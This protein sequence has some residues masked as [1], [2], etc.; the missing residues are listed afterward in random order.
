MNQWEKAK[1]KTYGNDFRGE[2]VTVFK[3]PEYCGLL[4]CH[5]LHTIF[6][7]ESH[8]LDFHFWIISRTCLWSSQSLDAHRIVFKPLN[9]LNTRE[10]QGWV[11]RDRRGLICLSCLKFDV[12]VKYW[13]K[14]AQCQMLHTGNN[15]DNKQHFEG[16]FGVFGDVS[17]TTTNGF[18]SVNVA[19]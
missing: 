19:D 7:V 10:I 15:G 2:N 13:L 16:L 11:R 1:K 18:W 14:R 3:S 8:C 12:T 9:L 5:D 4:G 17:Y 6:L